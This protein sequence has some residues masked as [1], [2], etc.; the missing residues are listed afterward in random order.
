MLSHKPYAAA[1]SA[2]SV[3]QPFG[4]PGAQHAG[5][6][7]DTPLRG[8]EG[9]DLALAAGS[10]VQAVQAGAVLSL[11]RAGSHPRFGRYV[12]LGH[13]WG[14]SLYANLGE[15]DAA[16]GTGM[17]VGGGQPIGHSGSATPQAAAHLHFGLRI[18]PFSVADGYC[19]YSDPQ[20]YLDRIVQGRGAIIGPHILGGVHQ[21]LP[22]LSQWQPRLITVV[23]PNPDEMKLLREACPHSTI[24]ARIFAPDNEVSERIKANPEAAAAW[25]HDLVQARKS[26][27]V[28]YWQVANE[29]LSGRDELPLLAR[30]ELARMA[31]AEPAGY[32]CALFAFSVGNPDLPEAA[33]MD[34]WRLLYPALE[35]AEAGGHIVAVHQYGAPDLTQPTIDWHIHRLEHQVL[36][37]LPFKRLQ[38]AVTEFGID[39]LLLGGTP[40]GWSEFGSAQ[41]YVQ[42]LLRA[43]R[44]LERW[45]GR[46]LGYSVFS[47]GVTGGWGSYDIRG[48]VTTMLAEQSERGT[49]AQVKT[50]SEGLDPGDG[51]APT[52]PGGESGTPPPPPPPPPPVPGPD[53]IALT[54]R[55]G[56]WIEPLN[57][58]IKSIAQ[59]PDHPTGE[60]HY[61]VKD[62]FTTRDGSWDPSDLMGSVEAWARDAY[63]KPFGAPDYFDDAGADHHLFACVLGLDGKPL[64]E[65]EIRYWSDGFA[66]LGVPGYNGYVFRQTKSHSGWANIPMFGSNY[67]PENGQQGPWCWTPLGAAE[68]VVGGGMPANHHISFFVVWQAV[69][70]GE[71]LPPPSGFNVFIPWVHGQG[72]APFEGEAPAPGAPASTGRPSQGEDPAAALARLRAEAWLR[73]RPEA[74]PVSAFALYARSLGLGAPLSAEFASGGWVAQAFAGGI[75]YASPAAPAHIAHIAW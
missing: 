10:P 74:D 21:H 61:L 15:V 37:R 8:H 5:G 66:Q 35:R 33:R 36:R 14:Q 30:F 26:P 46:V 68:V 53:P 62:I 57:V 4:A 58:E 34:V 28:D 51:D 47:L 69:K 63:L 3:L 38:F 59:R 17:S 52:V 64:P 60:I 49:W 7:G 43:G 72:E 41:S 13:T 54:V 31:L 1:E 6:C 32:R 16:I 2:P 25:A 71:T 75:V 23:D 9:I 56:R 20:P 50:G 27:V 24:V 44:H 48:E 65:Y 42:Q 67:Y 70:A 18:N 22:A 29:V 55:M 45:S 73:L 40:R 39:G 11:D 12:L 19:G